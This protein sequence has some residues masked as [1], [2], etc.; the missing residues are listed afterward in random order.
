MWCKTIHVLLWRLPTHQLQRSQVTTGCLSRLNRTTK[1]STNRWLVV[2]SSLN[3]KAHAG[4][5]KKGGERKKN[6]CLK[7]N[8]RTFQE[9]QTVSSYVQIMGRSSIS[10]RK[11][12]FKKFLQSLRASFV[13]PTLSRGNNPSQPPPQHHLS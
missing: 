7:T 4:I 10:S 13:I 5:L 2:V 8:P 3:V 6:S 9:G 12:H 11:I 1:S